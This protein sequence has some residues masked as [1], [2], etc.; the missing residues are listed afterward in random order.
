MV[1]LKVIR[2]GAASP[3][4]LRRFHFEASM[5]G[6]LRHIGIAQI[7]E[8]GTYDDSV[9]ARP[10]FAMEHV[11]GKQ[12]ASFAREKYLG[13]RAKLELLANVCDAVQHAHQHG[14][15]HRDLK[16]GN[17][18]VDETG[19]PT[20]L[21][22]GVACSA[23][24]GPHSVSTRPGALLG[25]IEYMSPEQIDGG[26]EEVDT[27]TDIYSLGVIMYELLAGR[28]PHDLTGLS[29]TAAMGHVRRESVPPLG[30][31]HRTLRGDIETICA[32]AMEK[33]KTRRYE[34]ASALRA[35][36]HRLLRNEPI[37]ARPASAI[38]QLRKL[39]KR[40]RPEGRVIAHRVCDAAYR[41]T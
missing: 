39:A 4:T 19:Q 29:M 34:S 5:L 36:I 20:V 31:I 9:G 32:K 17:I 30:R 33:D 18:L 22:F 38:Y 6:K 7:Y 37:T 28:M 15:I 40:N 21:D 3:E 27:R 41:S 14:V 2:P 35:D 13:T 1:A 16:P 8:A 10:Y 11:A 24:R 25:T 23:D 12:L 26:T